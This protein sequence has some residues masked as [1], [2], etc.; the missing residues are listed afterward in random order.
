M[1]IANDSFA[2][3]PSATGFPG[4]TSGGLA[5]KLAVVAMA[6]S[7]SHYWLTIR[8]QDGGGVEQN[9]IQVP[10]GV[11]LSAPGIA[12]IKNFAAIGPSKTLVLVGRGTDSKIWFATNTLRVP[13]GGS[14]IAYE[15]S[16]WSG[17]Q[18][19]KTKTFVGAP[20]ITY[21][22]ARGNFEP[23]LMVAARDS[24]GHFWSTKSF[25]AVNWSDWVEVP[26][27]TF[28]DGP[29]LGTG[30]SGNMQPEVTIFGRGL[31]NKVYVSAWPTT[32]VGGFSAITNATFIGSPQASCGFTNDASHGRVFVSAIQSGGAAFSN[33]ANSP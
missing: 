9:W 4:I 12:F 30:V 22:F 26:F 5:G 14:S 8:D 3:R 31:D 13:P 25:D 21:G 33:K 11:F 27:G 24:N 7:D 10:F 19:I 29:A 28:F 32:G 18:P 2:T 23:M 1:P 17:F 20:A 15:N 6:N 16:R